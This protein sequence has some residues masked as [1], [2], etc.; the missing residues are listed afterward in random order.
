ME[1]EEGW[2]EEEVWWLRD[3]AVKEWLFRRNFK[4]L[5]KISVFSRPVYDIITTTNVSCYCCKNGSTPS[6]AR[7]CNALNQTAD[8]PKKSWTK[9]NLESFPYN[10]IS[11]GI[12]KLAKLRRNKFIHFSPF[13]DFLKMTFTEINVSFLGCFFPAQL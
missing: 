12:T 11:H 2:R 6:V 4:I 10:W 3:Y 9:I 8:Y 13:C 7:F 1:G 5:S